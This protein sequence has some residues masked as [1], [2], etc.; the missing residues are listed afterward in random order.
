MRARNLKPGFFKNAE[1]AEIHPLGRLLWQGMWCLADKS[2]R[3]DDRPK[4]IKAEVLPYD[5]NVKILSLIEQL[6]EHGFIVRYEANAKRYIQVVNF[7]KH[8]SPHIH[9]KGSTIPAPDMHGAKTVAIHLTPDVL[10]PDIRITDSMPIRAW[11][12]LIWKNYPR[13]EGRKA[14]ERYFKASV[15]TAEDWTLIQQALD[16]YK[17]QLR[18][19][20]TDPQFIKQGSTW[21]NNWRDYIENP[22][23][24]VKAPRAPYVPPVPE[25]PMSD[26]DQKAGLEFV[27]HLKEVLQS[28]VK[29]IAH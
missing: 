22:V 18:F 2:G 9:E 26:E 12:D 5:D 27:K 3:L 17:R 14:S 6:A 15:H 10:T 28:G 25:K 7:D 21:F 11:F 29:E 1:L 23:T 13:R 8:Q 4:Q 20:K 24:E 19:N 16:N